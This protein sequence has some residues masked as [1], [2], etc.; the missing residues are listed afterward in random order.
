M[1]DNYLKK[2]LRGVFQELNDYI[3]EHN[4]RRFEEGGLR[5]EKQVLKIAGQTALF[6][7]DLPFPITATTDLDIVVTLPYAVQVK[8][9]ELL[10]KFGIV[11]DPDGRLVWMPPDTV[12]HP[13]FDST[14]VQALYADPE[15]VMLSKYKFNR[16]D[17]RKLLQTYAQYF[18]G[19]ETAVA[20]AGL[21]RSR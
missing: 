6:L 9:R 7:A 8:L 14:W 16:P 3:G 2:A 20:K 1:A 10:K 15:A 17:D 5:I 11:L 13:Y 4:A 12:Y 19:F 21:K 18:P